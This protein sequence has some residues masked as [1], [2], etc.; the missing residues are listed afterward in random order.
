[1]SQLMMIMLAVFVMATLGRLHTSHG[2]YRFFAWEA[3]LIIFII[4]LDHWLEDPFSLHQLFS[5]FFLFVSLFLVIYGFWMLWQVGK[6]DQTRQET[7]LIGVEK[8][9]VLITRGIYRNIRHPLYSSLLFLAWGI[10]FKSYTLVT[11]SLVIVATVF[12]VATARSEE[13]E[14]LAHFGPAYREYMRHTK[15]FIPFIY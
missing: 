13:S 11:A 15:M 1:M 2:F 4:N 9:S 8:T 3:I 12:L 6:P 7:A 14:N 5:W 10:F